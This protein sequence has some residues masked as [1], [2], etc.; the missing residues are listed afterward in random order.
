M[1][2]MPVH[3]HHGVLVDDHDQRRDDNDRDPR[4]TRLLALAPPPQH[5]DDEAIEKFA[6][7]F[8]EALADGFER[9]G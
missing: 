1:D 7:G 3:D 6:E 5:L 2:D 9:S 8:F 4:P